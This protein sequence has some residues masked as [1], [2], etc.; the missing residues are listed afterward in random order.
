[1]KKWTSK[2]DL[3]SKEFVVIPVNEAYALPSS[4]QVD[5]GSAHWYVAI[6]CNLDKARPRKE[7]PPRTRSRIDHQPSPTT[8]TVDLDAEDLATP[9]ITVDE[10]S[11]DNDVIMNSQPDDPSD[12]TSEILIDAE[13]GVAVTG[14]EADPI[15]EPEPASRLE[16]IPTPQLD[17]VPGRETSPMEIDAPEELE[18][19]LRRMS[20]ASNPEAGQ[21]DYD[22]KN[23]PDIDKAD[24]IAIQ[25]AQIPEIRYSRRRTAAAARKDDPINIDDDEGADSISALLKQKYNPPTTKSP[26]RRASNRII[27][28]DSYTPC[29]CASNVDGRV[30]IIVFDSLGLKHVPTIK[31][32]RDYLVEEAKSKRGM[33]LAKEDIVGMHAK[34]PTQ[35]NYCDCGVF[36]LHYVEK[37]LGEPER[38][39]PDILVS[40][41][42]TWNFWS[43]DGD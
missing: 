37:F 14:V 9:R 1:M 34:V 22:F 8:E 32:L 27:P 20:I 18:K 42:P 12:A 38:Y 2:V 24:R 13:K 25:K 31:A 40:P 41:H 36:L 43:L 29:P 5:V 28:P 17:S 15:P 19:N 16:P 35:S 26:A 10:T 7:Q 39:L 23:N 21:P 33:D 6:I 4:T 30:V 11:E 3:F